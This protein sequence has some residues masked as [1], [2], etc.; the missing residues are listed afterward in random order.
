MDSPPSNQKASSREEGGTMDPR[1]SINLPYPQGSADTPQTSIT[2]QTCGVVNASQ[3]TI[4]A[5]THG[6]VNAPQIAHSHIEGAVTF[7]MVTHMHNTGNAREDDFDRGH[8]AVKGD[9]SV[10]KVSS[11][12]KSNLKLKFENIFEGLAKRGNPTLLNRMFTEVYI[13]EGEKEVVIGEHIYFQM[14]D[15]KRPTGFSRED[16]RLVIYYE[17][18]MRM[19]NTAPIDQSYYQMVPK[20]RQCENFKSPF[21]SATDNLS[22]HEVWQL[23]TAS[24]HQTCHEPAI[25]CN[26]IFKPL[27]GQDVHIRTVLT[28]GVAGIGKTVSVQKFILDWAEEKANQDVDFI[29]VLPFRELNRFQNS[30]LSLHELLEIFHPELK[31]MKDMK[32]YGEAKIVVIF[33]GLDESYLPLS[34]Q[35]NRIVADVAKRSSLDKL[36]I[37]LFKGN[38][39]PSA[40]IWITS[41][42]AAVHRIRSD[43]LHRVTEIRG[44]NDQ[45]KEEYFRKRVSDEMQADTIISHLR[46]SKSLHTM[47]HIPVFCWIA[48]TVL[49]G[50]QS[51]T[52]GGNLSYTLTGMYTRF[53]LIQTNVKNQKYY[54]KD[55]RDSRELS[56]SDVQIL[57]QI[58]KLAFENLE[59]SKL[60]FS[61]RDLK[62]YGLNTV[63]ISVHS[64]LFTEILKKEDPMF[65]GQW[66]SFVHLS[67]QEFL[68]AVY[69]FLS[70]V[71]EQVD[72]SQLNAKKGVTSQNSSFDKNWLRDSMQPC[73]KSG[74]SLLTREQYQSYVLDDSDCDSED[75]PLK[76][77]DIQDEMQQQYTP[78]DFSTLHEWHRVAVDKSLKSKNGH[79]DLFLQFL[80][81]LS[82]GANYSLFRCLCLPTGIF[83]ED[84]WKTTEYIKHKLRL[85]DQRKCPTP[86]RCINLLNCLTEVGDTTVTGEIQSYIMSKNVPEKKLTTAQC[87]GLAYM[88]L[89]SKNVL[90]EFDLKKYRTSA[91]GRRRLVPLVRCCRKALLANCQLT[92]NCFETIS[93]VL[94]TSD[95][96][97]R[98]LDLSHNFLVPQTLETLCAGLVSPHCN[99]DSLNLSCINLEYTG[100]ILLKA[101]LLGPHHQPSCLRLNGCYLEDDCSEFILTAL[102]SEKSRLTLLDLSY[103][104]LTDSGIIQI[105]IGLANPNCKLY[106]L[107]LG[108]CAITKVSCEVLGSVLQFSTLRELD[109]SGSGVGNEG[110]KRIFSRTSTQLET[111]RLR[112]CGLSDGACDVLG[113]T[114][115]SSGLKEL[116]LRDNNIRDSG[117]KLLCV[118]L[119]KPTCIL[120][121]LGLSGCLITKEGCRYLA[122]AL[123]ANPSHLQ[124]LDL[125]YN[126]P[127]ESGVAI[128]SEALEDPNYKLATLNSRDGG[129]HRIKPMLRKYAHVLTLDPNTQDKSTRFFLSEDKRRAYMDF[130]DV[131]KL[132]SYCRTWFGVSCCEGLTGG[133]FYWEVEWREEVVIGVKYKGKDSRYHKESWSLYCNSRTAHYEASHNNSFFRIAM[134]DGESRRVGVCLDWPAGTLSFYLAASDRL[135]HL[136][137]FHSDFSKPLYPEFYLNDSWRSSVKIVTL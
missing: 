84:I 105:L 70:F 128:L 41:R 120:Q 40:H 61:E 104:S 102:Q 73:E 15:G 69:V 83:Q 1:G 25:N 9:A 133:R 57:L 12:L 94:Q 56:S 23:N 121:S 48:S 55:E 88:M 47:C 6:V 123:K 114:L 22:E 111:L 13:T 52:I 95:S 81:G 63:E 35:R 29:F 130:S 33:D 86:E 129:L 85:E 11:K 75:E 77:S 66:Y 131:Q 20:G 49:G 50:M 126:H 132:Y 91:G 62:R 87:S 3:S 89:T 127:G 116:E 39:L 2:A 32:K 21:H 122:S 30:K 112:E 97:L 4:T 124:V 72:V 93:S 34:F 37:N 137:T 58:G 96:L 46:A 7:N 26:D 113:N 125:S 92:R 31:D 64:G 99:L 115:S 109:L 28:K 51:D 108:G 36:L 76:K 68:A 19:L 14:I 74:K 65:E 24:R 17:N 59:K 71:R 8:G 18:S 27:P 82:L 5:Q 54:D 117:V 103:N 90:D 38:L 16:G 60:I 98:E 43:C 101:A 78:Q 42:P 106:T 136:H 79:L 53:L 100:S 44:F 107:R 134:A 10:H 80:L 45:Q 118:G 119:A 67:I 110:V 135:R